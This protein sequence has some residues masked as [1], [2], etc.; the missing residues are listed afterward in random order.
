MGFSRQL[1]TAEHPFGKVGGKQHSMMPWIR[2]YKLVK[3]AKD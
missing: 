1:P 2:K 3:Q